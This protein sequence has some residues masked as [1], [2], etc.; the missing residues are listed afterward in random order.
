MIKRNSKFF[1][2]YNLVNTYLEILK[3][4]SNEQVL[5]QLPV[6]NKNRL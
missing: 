1:N 5:F 3:V 2:V 6:L 4:R